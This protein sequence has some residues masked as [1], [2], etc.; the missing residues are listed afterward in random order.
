MPLANREI[1]LPL[2]RE[3]GGFRVSGPVELSLY[4]TASISSLTRSFT[5]SSA[6]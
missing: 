5:V 1:P 4:P 3:T 2:V 6:S